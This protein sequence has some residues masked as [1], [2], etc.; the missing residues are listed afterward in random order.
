MRGNHY[1]ADLV[2]LVYLGLFLQEYPEAKQWLGYAAPKL[3]TEMQ[4]QVYADG[5]DHE[6]AL[7]YHRLVAE[8]FL[9]AAILLKQN[10]LGFSAATMLC[11]EKMLEFAAAYT[12]PDGLCPLFGDTD[13][14]RLHVLG[15]Q[16]VNDHR[17][18]LSTGAVLFHRGDLKARAVRFWEESAW[19]LGATSFHEFDRLPVA[20]AAESAAFAGG[21]YWIMRQGDDY[22]LVDCGDV[23][24][25]SR[26]GHGHNDILSFEWFLTGI[27]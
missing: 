25:R 4:H 24:T 8:M 14:G 6:G 27:I 21:G 5:V 9:S 12:K 17:Y 10:G 3:E 1:L 20:P 16:P 26:G 19:L 22:L 2:G 23:G 13:D 7:P 15:S 18:L 11:L